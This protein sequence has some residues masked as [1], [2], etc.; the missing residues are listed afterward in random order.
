MIKRAL[1]LL[2]LLAITAVQTVWAALPSGYEE[3]EYIA[4][5]GTQYI[6]TGVYPKM[7][8]RLICD[9]RFTAI[10]SSLSLCGWGSSGSKEVFYFG[11]GKTEFPARPQACRSAA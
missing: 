11:C 1:T 4:S 7:T 5:S 6:D 2:S 8:T 10:P 3:L 9:F